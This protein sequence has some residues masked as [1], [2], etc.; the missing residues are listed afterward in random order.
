MGEGRQPQITE[1]APG[2]ESWLDRAIGATRNASYPL[3][4]LDP[5]DPRD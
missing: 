4:G 2:G 1:W 3:L 5:D